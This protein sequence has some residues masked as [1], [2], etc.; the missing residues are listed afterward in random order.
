VVTIPQTAL[1]VE[2]FG[3][4]Q[5]H[6]LRRLLTEFRH[7]GWRDPGDAALLVIRKIE[8]QPGVAATR[9]AAAAPAAFFD[10]NHITKKDLA[11]ALVEIAARR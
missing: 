6:A 2:A 3:I 9:A 5:K 11:A 10:L 8:K 4:S 1:H 7:R